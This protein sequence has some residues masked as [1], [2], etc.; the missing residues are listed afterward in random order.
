MILFLSFEIILYLEHYLYNKE[1]VERE[2][3]R[4]GRKIEGHLITWHGK[5]HQNETIIA[6]QTKDQKL[7][8]RKRSCKRGLARYLDAGGR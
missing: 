4:S 8:E 7:R 1:M 6:N 5:M 3:E 2:R